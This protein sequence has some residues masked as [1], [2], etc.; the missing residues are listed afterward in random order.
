[1]GYG[2]N[3]TKIIYI[4]V[5]FGNSATGQTRRRV[6]KHDGSNDVEKRAYYQNYCINSNQILHSDKD[7]QMPFVGG[8]HTHYKSKMA[9]DRHLGKIEKLLYQPRFE[10]FW[11]NLARWCSLTVLTVLT[12]KNWEI[13]KLQDG[14]GHHLEKFKNSHISA[15]VWP[16]LMK[17]G[18]MLQFVPLDR[19]DD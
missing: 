13:S 12:V 15:A 7:H 1:M 3:M 8:P 5:L 18:T 2:W 14:G 6:F 9:D 11:R 17:F 10:R 16:I 4:Y 19:S